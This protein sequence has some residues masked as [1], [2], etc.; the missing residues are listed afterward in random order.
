METFPWDRH[1]LAELLVAIL[2]GCLPVQLLFDVAAVLLVFSPQPFDKSLRHGAQAGFEL[3]ILLFACL[4]NA[5]ITGMCC[6]TWLYKQVLLENQ[7]FKLLVFLFSKWQSD[8][9]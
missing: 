3:A 8:A 2:Q 4:L 5:G 9:W 7:L 6:H 1:S